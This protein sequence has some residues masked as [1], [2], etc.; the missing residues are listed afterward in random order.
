MVPYF[1]VDCAIGSI[2]GGICEDYFYLS[3]E[4]P[5]RGQVS[6]LPSVLAGAVSSYQDNAVIIGS[7]NLNVGIQVIEVALPS[8]SFIV[9]VT[10][11]PL[12][13]LTRL[14]AIYVTV[15]SI[16]LVESST[17]KGST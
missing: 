6:N 4:I 12:F 13:P 1:N 5:S 7:V 15:T 10:I 8:A 2:L 17:V 3:Q 9:K 16:L 14:I 11:F